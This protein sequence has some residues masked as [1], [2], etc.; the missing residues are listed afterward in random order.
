MNSGPITGVKL[1]SRRTFL[2]S[3]ATAPAFAISAKAAGIQREAISRDDR[4]R[5]FIEARYGMFIHWGAY[6]V[7]A[8]GE[9]YQFEANVP[10]TQY[11]KYIPQ[12][13]PVKF[14]AR[15]W[16]ALAKQAGMKY[17]VFTA[18]HHD[19]FCM[20][21]TALTDF[22]I[23]KATMFRR[24][25]V[26]ELPEECKRQGIRFCI[27]Y[28][29]KDWHHP[30]YPKLYTFR[31][32]QQPDGFHGAPNPGANYMKYLDYMQAQLREL[33]TDYGPIWELFFDW[34]GDAFNVE[35]HKRRGEEIV[36]MIRQL[37]PQCLINNR[38]G[39]IGADYGTPEQTIPGGRQSSAFE[40]CM[41]LNNNWGYNKDDHNW[42]DAK[43]VVSQ[44][45][46]SV[47][48]GGNYLLNVGPDAQ[49]IIPEPSVRVLREVGRWLDV[50]GE[51]VYGAGPGPSVEWQAD[52]KMVTQKRNKDYLHVFE[53]PADGRIYYPAEP[54]RLK[55]AYLLADRQERQLETE[56]FSRGGIMVRVPATAPDP[57]DSIVVIE[58]ESTDQPRQSS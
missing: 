13:N 26:K 8:R 52:L 44:L 50:N 18:K 36:R 15:D 9:W 57:I 19:G 41:T 49:G 11:E 54:R 37:Q 17:M 22:S 45:C 14:N 48:R 32:K 25:P 58:F 55:R 1:S 27:Y 5:W 24:D 35:T 30:E 29:V 6:S 21:N 20:W 2:S 10:Q 39:G 23:V 56:T 3:L 43:T 38:L 47:A 33:M 31:T 34:C 40:V 7:P 28:S 53:W 42:K 12:F 4:L 51:A 16:V 46:S